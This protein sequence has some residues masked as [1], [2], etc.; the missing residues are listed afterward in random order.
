MSLFTLAVLIFFLD[1]IRVAAV[2][3]TDIEYVLLNVFVN[4]S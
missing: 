1:S 3:S 4:V 2:D